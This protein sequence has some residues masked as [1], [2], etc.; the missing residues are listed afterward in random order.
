M[1]G[2]MRRSGRARTTP[3]ARSF[4]MSQLVMLVAAQSPPPAP[5]PPPPGCTCSNTCH[6][7]NTNLDIQASDGLCDD[8]GPGAEWADCPY[9]T[10]C[11]DCG[12]R[13]GPMPPPEPPTPP[14][15]PLTTPCYCAT[16]VVSSTDTNLLRVQADLMG[17]YRR[18]DMLVVSGRQVYRQDGG[19][20]YYIHYSA[21][22]GHWVFGPGYNRIHGGS[23]SI[24]AMTSGPSYA[25]CPDHVT[26]TP[27]GYWRY[28]GGASW[29]VAPLTITAMCPPSPPP[30][31]LPPDA[32]C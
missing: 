26:A 11:A 25:A 18:D 19:A 2:V 21:A 31:P 1:T 7:A 29:S 17:T 20:Y 13:C 30:P 6:P 4:M 8:G 22:Q 28:W 14:P 27:E 16:M 12:M 5:Q 9:G 23:A 24:V 3:S 32:S 10:D 15:P